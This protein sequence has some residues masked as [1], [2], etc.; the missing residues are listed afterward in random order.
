M[1]VLS[2]LLIRG[3]SV[4]RVGLNMLDHC[5]PANALGGAGKRW[6]GNELRLYLACRDL[7]AA[8]RVWAAWTADNGFMN[9]GRAVFSQLISFLP[10][11]EFRRCVE[12]YQGDSRLR[13]FSC[14]DQYLSMAFAQLTY[15]E[16]L[17]DIEVCL[18]SV[19]G[20]LYHPDANESHMYY[21]GLDVH[22]KTISYCVRD[23][24]GQVHQEG[25]IGA[26]RRELD[27]RMKTI[28]QPWTV[29]MESDD[30]R[31]LDLRSSP[32]AC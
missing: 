23:A 2:S 20:K 3:I 25:E 31:R 11:R 32:S 18:H 24:S 19:E 16:S 26:T 8:R 12:R 21:I 28:P 29:A 13:G 30:F 5:R 9:Q 10:D 17:R 14:W 15:R 1:K 4:V 27:D 22:K 6:T 7:N